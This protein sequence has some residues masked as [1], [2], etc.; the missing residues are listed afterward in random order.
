MDDETVLRPMP[1]KNGESLS[2][3]T[4]LD[5]IDVVPV[6]QSQRDNDIEITILSIESYNT[7]PV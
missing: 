6:A 5:L 1:K 4:L 2:S 3:P 7:K